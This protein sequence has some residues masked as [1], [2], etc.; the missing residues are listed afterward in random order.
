M[1]LSFEELKKD[2]GLPD[3]VEKGSWLS[4]VYQITDKNDKLAFIEAAT[5]PPILL[6]AEEGFLNTG[7][8]PH[9]AAETK[10]MRE[11]FR[12]VPSIRSMYDKEPT[13]DMKNS[14]PWPAATVLSDPQEDAEEEAFLDVDPEVEHSSTDPA[15]EVETETLEEF[16]ENLGI[17]PDPEPHRYKVPTSESIWYFEEDL[18]NLEFLHKHG[19]ITEREYFEATNQCIESFRETFNFNSKPMYVT[20][21]GETFT[22]FSPRVEEE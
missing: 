16:V 4:S 2:V 6:W 1:K 17:E 5:N 14:W 7:Y 8:Y 13:R 11:T 22:Q 9:I 20:W 3:S 21:I 12:E 18:H 10:S 15:E 19:I